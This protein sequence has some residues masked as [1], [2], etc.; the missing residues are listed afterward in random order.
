MTSEMQAI[1]SAENCINFGG[2]I[3]QKNGYFREEV[4]ESVGIPRQVVHFSENVAIIKSS[5]IQ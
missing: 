4:F 2:Y 5:L 1:N 3:I